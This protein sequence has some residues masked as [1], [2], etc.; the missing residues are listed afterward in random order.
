[1][2]KL[3]LILSILL[4]SRLLG[5]QTI[6][7]Y[8]IGLGSLVNTSSKEMGSAYIVGA[9]LSWLYKSGLVLG[10]KVD[11]DYMKEKASSTVNVTSSISIDAKLAY[12]YTN[13]TLYTLGGY[14]VSQDKGVY[15]NLSGLGY[16]AGV[17]WNFFSD[18]SLTLE[19]KKYSMS[20]ASLGYELQRTA[21]FLQ[22]EY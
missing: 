17:S 14:R 2:R 20:T 15:D 7:D 3:F 18:I 5:T 1:M 13:L 12:R 21:F 9:G 22:Y 8:H 19:Y 11:Y 16:G 4:S 6:V 10:G